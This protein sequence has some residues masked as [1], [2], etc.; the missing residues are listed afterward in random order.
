[1]ARPIAPGGGRRHKYPTS[2]ELKRW[3]EVVLVLVLVGP[4]WAR[5]WTTGWPRW[6]RPTRPGP[7]RAWAQL[8]LWWTW[9]KRQQL[10]KKLSMVELVVEFEKYWPLV[11]RYWYW[12]L[13]LLLQ[14]VLELTIMVEVEVEIW[15]VSLLQ[16]LTLALWWSPPLGKTRPLHW[17]LPSAWSWNWHSSEGG[18]TFLSPESGAGISDFS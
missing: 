9:M 17:T 1:M 3:R 6:S 10:A 18:A 13:L 14:M 2:S 5:T 12:R 15:L 8:M 4:L 16:L 7:S 11:E